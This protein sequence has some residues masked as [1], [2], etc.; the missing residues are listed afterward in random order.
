MKLLQSLFFLFFAASVVI[1]PSC[2][3]EEKGPPALTAAALS[4]GRAGVRFSTSTNFNGSRSFD[5]SNT[6]ST[7]A[8]NTTFSSGTTRNIILEVTEMVDNTPT[9][10]VLM[11]MA[12][13]NT[14]STIDLSLSSGFPLAF[15]KLESYSLLGIFRYSKS[16]TITLTKLTAT[17]VEGTFTATFDDGLVASNGQFAGKF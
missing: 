16:G 17:E 14:S 7:V 15:I 8:T 6:G 1:L 10:K 9:R 12:V 3:K 13:K 11:N 4:A 2:K 5:V